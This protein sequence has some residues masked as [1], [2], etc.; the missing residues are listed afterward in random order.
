MASLIVD[1]ADLVVKMSEVE[2]FEAVHP[3]VRV[4][5]SAL[6]AVRVVDDAWPELRG[7]RAP[8]TGIPGVIAVGTRRGSFGKDFAVVH[9]KAPAVVVD[10]MHA[11]YA[12]LVVTTP[13]TESVAAEIRNHLHPPFSELPP[14]V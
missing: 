12:R 8:G 10:L 14:P 4:P 6:R 1:G 3:D 11:D 5:M 7:I 9:G 13:D 2:K